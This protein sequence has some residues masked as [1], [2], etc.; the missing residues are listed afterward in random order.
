MQQMK[1]IFSLVTSLALVAA[2]FVMAPAEHAK[3]DQPT[4]EITSPTA[5]GG[6]IFVPSRFPTGKS[7]SSSRMG[8]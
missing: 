8:R 3:A 6:T 1:R 5:A 7:E 2:I 4:L